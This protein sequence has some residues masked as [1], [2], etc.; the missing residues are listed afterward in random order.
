VSNYFKRLKSMIAGSALA[1]GGGTPEAPSRI[2]EES[3]PA[4]RRSDQ[5]EITNGVEDMLAALRASSKQL[6]R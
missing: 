5:H 3:A 6:T 2:S 4:S 1:D